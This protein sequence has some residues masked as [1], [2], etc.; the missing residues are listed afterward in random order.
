MGYLAPAD[1]NK[2]RPY[3]CQQDT[4]ELIYRI[5]EAVQNLIPLSVPDEIDAAVQL[6]SERF[7]EGIAFLRKT[8]CYERI[9]SLTCKGIAEPCRS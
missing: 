8:K 1:L 6:R 7:H 9:N 5:E 3:L 2:D 4:E